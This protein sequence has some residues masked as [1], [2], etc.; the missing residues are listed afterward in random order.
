MAV[1]A[2]STTTAQ[3]EKKYQPDL[4]SIV[5]VAGTTALLTYYNGYK[6]AT[7]TGTNHQLPNKAIG[8]I[9][10]TVVVT[11][12]TVAV[13]ASTDGT[14]FDVKMN[15]STSTEYSLFDDTTGLPVPSPGNLASGTYRIPYR[16]HQQYQAFKFTKTGVN[17]VSYLAVAKIIRTP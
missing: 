6:P 9:V 12:D 15:G 11:T 3:Q 14:N 4:V 16:Y 7:G 10:F 17:A 2:G 13:T 8:D 5:N 1:I